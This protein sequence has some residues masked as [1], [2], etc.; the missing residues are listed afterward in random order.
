MPDGHGTD[1]RGVV[2]KYLVYEYRRG[3]SVVARIRLPLVQIYLK[4]RKADSSTIALVDS[5]AT[6]TMMPRELSE[7]LSLEFQEGR[8][9][10]EGAGGRFYSDIARLERLSIMKN[11]T[12]FCTLVGIEV[13]VPERPGILPYVVLGRDYFFNRFD[14]TFHER[15]Q[16]MAFRKTK[17]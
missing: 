3:G 12:P 11:V 16:K 5:G 7:V 4:S 14:I 2:C 15:R 1:Y 13:L 9:E 6:R 10:T 8:V 17:P